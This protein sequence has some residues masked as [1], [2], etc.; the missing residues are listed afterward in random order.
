MTIIAVGA[1]GAPFMG[2]VMIANVRIVRSLIP[3]FGVP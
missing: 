2:Y 1:M 3:C